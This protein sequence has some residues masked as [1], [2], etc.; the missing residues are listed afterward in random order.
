M[1]EP[2]TSAPNK[3]AVSPSVPLT[4]PTDSKPA[5]AVSEKKPDAPSKATSPAEVKKPLE[6]A[7]PG[8]GKPAPAI[9]EKKPDTP[10][11]VISLADAKKPLEQTKPGD[12]KPAPEK[13]PGAAEK[14]VS[15][16]NEKKAQENTGKEKPVAAASTKDSKQ[17]K[18]VEPPKGVQITQV[19]ADR[20]EKPDEKALKNL[21][22]PKEGEAFSMRLHPSYFFDFLEHPFTV[23]REVADYQD[24][25]DSIKENGI[26]EPVKARPRKD[27]GLELISG[28]RRHDIAARLNYPVPVVVVQ[29][30]DDTARIEV[31]DGNLHRMDIPTSELARAAKMKMDAMKRKAGRRTKM[32]QLAEPQKRTDQLV[33]EDMGMSRNQVNRLTRITELVPDLQKMVDDKKLPFNTAVEVSFLSKPEQ[34]DMV[35][36]I[37][38][39]GVVPSMEQ[40]K[41]LKEAS[42]Q[43]AKEAQKQQEAAKKAVP[44]ATKAAAPSPAVEPPKPAPVVDMK[45]IASVITEKKEPGVKYVFTSGELKSYFPD[46]LPTVSEVKRAVFEAMDMRQRFLERKKAKETVKE[47]IKGAR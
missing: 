25:Y 41:M 12:G 39:E 29:M 42:Q 9:S 20:L 18:A 28:H 23:N 3:S 45:K 17:E 40:A 35:K 27:G 34:Q 10:G 5:P 24:L 13:K 47:E 21:P 33:A 4:K 2:V 16:A 8:E 44:A 38:K 1:P 19:F 11:K 46:D 6:Q 37:E 26:N 32:E 22:I 7:K 14:A 43:A 30:D 15:P 31:V 36:V